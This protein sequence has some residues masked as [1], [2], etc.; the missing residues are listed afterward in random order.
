MMTDKNQVDREKKKEITKQKSLRQ[1]TERLKRSKSCTTR[2]GLYGAA[3]NCQREPG[4]ARPQV[5]RGGGGEGL[6][7]A[8]HASCQEPCTELR[9]KKEIKQRQTTN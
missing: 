3:D 1:E 6:D 7:Q 2:P 4:V 8:G 5:W 9:G